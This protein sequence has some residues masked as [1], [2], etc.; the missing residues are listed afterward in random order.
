MAGD[1]LPS[2]KTLEKPENLKD[3]LKEDRGDDCLSCKV[4]GELA[5]ETRHCSSLSGS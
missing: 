5:L 3:L 2:V 4:V 1:K